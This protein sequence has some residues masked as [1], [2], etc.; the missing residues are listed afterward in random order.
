MNCIIVHGCPTKQTDD[1]ELRTYDKHWM[2]WT[3]EQLE[4]QG[5][6][7]EIPLMPEPWVPSYDRFKD[8]FEKFHV[9]ENTILVGHSCGCA[10]LAQWLAESKQKVAKLIFVAPWKTADHTFKKEYYSFD[11]DSTIKDRV[12]EIVMFTSYDENPNAQL[13]L[14]EYHNALDGKVIDLTDHEHYT[15]NDMGTVEFPELLDVIFD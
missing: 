13:S 15:F 7:T 8:V 4:K 2:P 1:P 11:V 12:G 10:F 6:P 9:D 3:K 14:D 5:I